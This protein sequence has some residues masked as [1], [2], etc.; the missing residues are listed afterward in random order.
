MKSTFKK[1]DAARESTPRTAI[2]DSRARAYGSEKPEAWAI[3]RAIYGYHPGRSLGERCARF[4][5]KY[6]RNIE[7]LLDNPPLGGMRALDTGEFSAA[8]RVLATVH[9]RIPFRGLLG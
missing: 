5:K 8:A 2:E 4:Q 3:Q 1:E 9:Y 6:Q 7:R